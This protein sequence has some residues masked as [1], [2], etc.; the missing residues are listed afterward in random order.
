MNK[1]GTDFFDDIVNIQAEQ[2]D[3]LSRFY[4]AVSQV[5]RYIEVEHRQQGYTH[6]KDFTMREYNIFVRSEKLKA[7][8]VIEEIVE[9]EVMHL[10]V[11]FDLP[12]YIKLATMVLLW[13]VNLVILYVHMISILGGDVLVF[14]CG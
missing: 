9:S 10:Q 6:N 5:G 12:W 4:F 2:D 1:K 7:G 14:L 3:A 13:P 11:P 8:M